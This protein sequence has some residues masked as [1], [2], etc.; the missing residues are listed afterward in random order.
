M[1]VYTLAT[2]KYCDILFE[3][4][5]FVSGRIFS[6]LYVYKHDPTAYR[7]EKRLQP[8]MSV[9]PLA[10]FNAPPVPLAR[11]VIT[12]GWLGHDARMLQIR[13]AA[14]VTF[15]FYFFFLLNGSKLASCFLGVHRFVYCIKG[16]AVSMAPDI[17]LRVCVKAKQNYKNGLPQSKWQ[18]RC[19]E[20]KR[21]DKL[22][23]NCLNS[24]CSTL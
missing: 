12:H 19:V 16:P 5:I 9:P 11:R 13:C 6:R 22:L 2:R 8:R 20:E 24:F 10:L 4:S 18:R 21:S 3:A 14:L 1:L 17:Q 23:G 15:F 7:R